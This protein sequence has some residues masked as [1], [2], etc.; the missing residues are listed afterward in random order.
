MKRSQVPETV[1]RLLGW[2]EQTGNPN[3]ERVIVIQPSSMDGEEWLWAGDLAESIGL[4]AEHGEV[5]GW[6]A[7]STTLG[8]QE[9][10][11]DYEDGATWHIYVVTQ[12]EE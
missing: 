12:E 8:A 1:E 10:T 6:C 4:A 9:L 3:A 2:F 11:G 5:Q 7:T